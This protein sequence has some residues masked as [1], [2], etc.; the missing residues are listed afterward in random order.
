MRLRSRLR[1]RLVAYAVGAM[2]L[3]G[4]LLQA[5]PAAAGEYVGPVVPFSAGHPATYDGP[6]AAVIKD[7]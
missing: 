7:Q 2:T 4:A 1:S 3:G 5:A 6:P